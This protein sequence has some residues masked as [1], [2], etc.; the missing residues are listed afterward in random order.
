MSY[1]LTA[2]ELINQ[3]LYINFPSL[4]RK[5]FLK[6][7]KSMLPSS[8]ALRFRN[9]SITVTTTKNSGPWAGHLSASRTS[10]NIL[11]RKEHTV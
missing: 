5:I 10:K 4:E 3:P 2:F 1:H 11:V 8:V 7:L 9:L 6:D